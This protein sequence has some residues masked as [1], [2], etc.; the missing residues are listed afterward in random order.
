M[1]HPDTYPE[2]PSP[3]G[4]SFRTL[5]DTS[6]TPRRTGSPAPIR[7]VNE[8][9]RLLERSGDNGHVEYGVEQAERVERRRRSS[10]YAVIDTG[11]SS[12]VGPTGIRGLAGDDGVGGFFC[13]F[14][15][16]TVC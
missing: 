1:A 13:L 7:N 16:A 6:S 10:S 5:D 11:T 3:S 4:A 12:G 14:F 2:I 9:S 8:R 15:P